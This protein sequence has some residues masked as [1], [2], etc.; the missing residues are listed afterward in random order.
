MYIRAA[1]AIDSLLILSGGNLALFDIETLEVK[2]SNGIG[3]VTAVAID[4]NPISGDPFL[5]EV[6]ILRV[7]K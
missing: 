6:S 4:E 3:N 2:G 1:S 7:S 5:V